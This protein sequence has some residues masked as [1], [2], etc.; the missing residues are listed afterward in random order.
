MLGDGDIGDEEQRSKSRRQIAGL[1]QIDRRHSD[2]DSKWPTNDSAWD[3]WDD[4]F[5]SSR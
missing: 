1:A 3:N 5:E 4:E 2:V